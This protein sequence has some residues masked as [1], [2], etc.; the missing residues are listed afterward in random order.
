MAW[1]SISIVALTI[2]PSCTT[3][4]MT[5][6]DVSVSSIFGSPGP[7]PGDVWV[8]DKHDVPANV[9]SAWAGPEHCGSQSATFLVMGW[10]I[11]ETAS[12][13][14]ERAYIRDQSGVISGKLAKGLDL[15]AHLPA[16][17]HRTGY[18]VRSV[19]LWTAASDVNVAVYLV[20]RG[21]AERWPR[22]EP[23]PLCS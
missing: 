11:G 18:S 7:Y 2:L 16:D 17:A 20:G 12:P 1:S 8:K 6:P 22:A 14:T 5:T 15:H 10:P 23:M 13:P 9:L 4:S 21:G 19:E 3:G